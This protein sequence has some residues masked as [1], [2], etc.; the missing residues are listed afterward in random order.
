M[1]YGQDQ[2]QLGCLLLALTLLAGVGEPPQ[3]EDDYAEYRE[4]RRHKAE[5]ALHALTEALYGKPEQ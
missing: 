5:Q 2:A 4:Y 3:P 1:S